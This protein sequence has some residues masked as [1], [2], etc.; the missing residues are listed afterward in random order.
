MNGRS[1]P[2]VKRRLPRLIAELYSWQKNSAYLTNCTARTDF[3]LRAVARLPTPRPSIQMLPRRTSVPVKHLRGQA[4]VSSGDPIKVIHVS[5]AKHF[6]HQIT[7][8]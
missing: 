5:V 2:S 4:G 7:R 8:R 3:L 6:A 1:L